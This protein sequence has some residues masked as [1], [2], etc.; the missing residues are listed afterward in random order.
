MLLRT[1]GHEA[2]HFIED[3]SA[4]SAKILT[5]FVIDALAKNGM[6]I[7]AQKAKLR[8][9]YSKDGDVTDA[10]ITAEIVAD[11]M[12]E[13]LNSKEAINRFVRKNSPKTVQRVIEAIDKVIASIRSSLAKMGQKLDGSGKY[14]HPEIKALVDDYEALEEIRKQFMKGME[15]ASASFEEKKN[16]KSAEIAAEGE[17]KCSVKSEIDSYNIKKWNDFIHVQRQVIKTLKDEQFLGVENRVLIYNNA[18]NEKIE[19]N[20]R[21]IKETIGN[22]TTFKKL[23]KELK[24]KK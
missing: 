24:T 11:G 2:Y 3:N 7:E 13:V 22:E 21:G 4:E 1:A 16:K 9:R 20:F 8:K 19:L 18:L 12:F 5:D 14:V 17:V 23:P 6:D 15:S 10:Q